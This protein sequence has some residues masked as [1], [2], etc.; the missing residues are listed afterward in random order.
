M[1]SEPYLEDTP[2]APGPEG[3][4]H[5]LPGSPSARSTLPAW[6]E[7]VQSDRLPSHLCAALTGLRPL[8]SVAIRLT[9]DAPPSN[10]VGNPPV[11]GICPLEYPPFS[12]ASHTLPLSGPEAMV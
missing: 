8:P 3:Q 12:Y 7:E 9:P 10:V 2:G 4:P 1:Q 6:G 11:V 5:T